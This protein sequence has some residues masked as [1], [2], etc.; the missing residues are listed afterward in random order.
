MSTHRPFLI[1]MMI[2]A[3]AMCAQAQESTVPALP[4]TPAGRRVAA[5]IQ[6]F[7]SEGDS[8]MR[9]FLS[10]NVSPADL[11][12][13]PIDARL[14]VYHQMKSNLGT[15]EI[16]RVLSSDDSSVS[17]VIRGSS[18]EWRQMTFLFSQDA[19]KSLRG[20]RAEDTEPLDR[21]GASG[22]AASAPSPG[23]ETELVARVQSY[24]DGLS[25]SDDFSGVVAIAHAKD[26]VFQNACG[27]ASKAGG[28]PNR[29]NTIF[30]LGSINKVFT[31]VAIG[32]LL[33]RGLLK[34][35][36]PI[37]R[38]L[39]DYPNQE[40]AK[41][42]TVRQLLSMTSGI[43][44]FFGPEF[45]A[46]PKDRIRQLSD[47]LPFFASKPLEFEPGTSRRYSNGGYIVLG[48]II[49]KVSGE[50]YYVYVRNNIFRPAGMQNSDWYSIDESV[51]NR[52]TGY[53]RENRAAPS[54]NERGDNT[55]FLPARG[56]SA[57]GGYS[58]A[59]DLLKF[60]LALQ[61][62]AL[63][64]P[65]FSQNEG[66]KRSGFPGLGIAGGSPGVN[67]ALEIEPETGY[68]V[69]VLSNYDPPSAEKVAKQIRQWLRTVKS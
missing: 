17:V 1:S 44:D 46:A 13:R 15:I 28:L 38:Y 10:G 27:L 5:C 40:A 26:L 63:R 53:T 34:L 35:D 66:A 42:V 54:S 60:S 49:Q 7:N 29:E 68:T 67:A 32:Q 59:G 25:K 12:Q 62:G 57:G 21:G 14:G 55:R 45:A 48:L 51:A 50:D 30:N 37:V 23:T 36:E 18:G 56:S 2:V 47:Y 52:A 8:A 65:D 61:S 6:A 64:I 41:K 69:I 11:Q 16:R 43:G 4:D 3:L 31:Q 58:T 19:A 24:L 39:P 22:P 20:I 33:D 9:A